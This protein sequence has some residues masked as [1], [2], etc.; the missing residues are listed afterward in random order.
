[1]WAKPLWYISKDAEYQGGFSLCIITLPPMGADQMNTLSNTDQEST[2]NYA[3]SKTH[4]KTTVVEP[5]G[6]R[7]SAGQRIKS[8]MA[9]LQRMIAEGKINLVPLPNF[10]NLSRAA[11]VGNT[12]PYLGRV[13]SSNIQEGFALRRFRPRYK[14]TCK[15]PYGYKAAKSCASKGEGFGVGRGPG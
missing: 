7:P 8:A 13:G 6:K 10:A 4:D 12:A 11:G 5:E 9:V 3:V 14:S 15:L 1:M 2:M